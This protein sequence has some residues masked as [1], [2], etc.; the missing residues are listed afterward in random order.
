MTLFVLIIVQCVSLSGSQ[1]SGIWSHM[2][3]WFC[4]HFHFYVRES[5]VSI[6]GN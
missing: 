5:I 4:K 6:I 3:E 2:P 1:Y